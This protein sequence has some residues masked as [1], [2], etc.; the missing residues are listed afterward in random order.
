MECKR[1]ED[2]GWRE[3]KGILRFDGELDE[4]FHEDFE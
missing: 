3:K 4:V 2:L 1:E